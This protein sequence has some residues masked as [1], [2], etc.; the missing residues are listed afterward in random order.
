[1]IASDIFRHEASADADYERNNLR[2]Y[3]DAVERAS[4][5]IELATAADVLE[6]F[7]VDS[8]DWKGLD[9]KNCAALADRTRKLARSLKACTKGDAD[10]F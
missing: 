6:R 5:W 9:Y 8:L 10:I 4:N 3:I 2:L 1:M 7:A